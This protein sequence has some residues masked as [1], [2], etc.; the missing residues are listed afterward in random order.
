MAGIKATFDNAADIIEGQIIEAFG[1]IADGMLEEIDKMSD[2]VI[3]DLK[4]ES[5]VGVRGKY[6][7]GWTKKPADD[8]KGFRIH[9][10]EY[11]LTHLLN[12]GHATRNGGWVNGDGH[13][14]KA[15]EDIER[16][17]RDLK[18]RAERGQVK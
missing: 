9:N 18:G 3:S 2:E 6:S 12:N 13:I 8:F 4:K 1:D 17:M 14:T 16:R 5:P 15:N 10:K 11:Q 7:K